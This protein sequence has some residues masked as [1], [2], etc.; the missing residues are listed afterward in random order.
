MKIK[1]PTKNFSKIKKIVLMS[2]N[3]EI[4]NCVLRINVQK[5]YN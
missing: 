3:N 5:E 1:I 2:L 4:E